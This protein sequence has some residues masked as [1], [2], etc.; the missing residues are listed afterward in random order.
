MQLSEKIIQLR[1]AK[2]MSQED[3]AVQLNISRQA[4]SRWENNS[5]LPDASN[6][7]QLSQLFEVSCDYLLNDEYE[8]FKPAIKKDMKKIIY[9]IAIIVG[10][11]GNFIIYIL[12]RMIEVMIPHITYSNG[13]KWYTWKSNLKGYSYKYFIMEHNLEL[14]TI[15][16]WILIVSGIILMNQKKIKQLLLKFKINKRSHSAS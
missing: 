15:F 13:Q 6:I 1:K 9:I 8:S 14:L 3:L 11:A 5:A 12:S 10:F 16:F 2:G 7:L 4:I